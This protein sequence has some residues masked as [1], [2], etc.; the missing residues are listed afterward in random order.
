[1]HGGLGLSSIKKND[2]RSLSQSFNI[3]KNRLKQLLNSK[4]EYAL[5]KFIISA[6]YHEKIRWI[7]YSLIVPFTVI[8]IYYYFMKSYI[9][10]FILGIIMLLLYIDVLLYYFNSKRVSLSLF[11]SFIA[12]TWRILRSLIL[13]KIAVRFII[14]FLKLRIL[15]ILL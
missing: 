15:K 5:L 3:I 14:K 12:L 6:P 9:L 11:F 10:L 8:S 1:M 2:H 13:I 7:T 4:Y